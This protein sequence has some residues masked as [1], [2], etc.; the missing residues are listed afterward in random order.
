MSKPDQLQST[1]DDMVQEG[2]GI[3][4]ADESLPTIAKRFKPIG[5]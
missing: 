5:V 3:L 1:I 2:R 4:A